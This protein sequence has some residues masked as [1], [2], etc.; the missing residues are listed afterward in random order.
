MWF[1][2]YFFPWEELGGSGRGRDSV[3]RLTNV[4]MHARPRRSA[5]NKAL[6]SASAIIALALAGAATPVRAQQ[7]GDRVRVSLPDST[8][9]GEVAAV[10]D[11]GFD[12]VRDST[13]F[14]FEYQS[15]D[16]LDRSVGTK[17]MGFEGVLLGA[18]I[19]IR[20]G[21]ELIT[22]CAGAIE[23]GSG[24]GAIFLGVIC[25]I[26]GLTIAVVGAPIGAVV[27]GVAGIFIHREEWAAIS[28]DGRHGRLSLLLPRFSP[29]GRVAM[30]LGLRIRIP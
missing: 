13:L 22:G 14:S 7:M 25:F 24:A 30:E 10:T 29:D 17:R 23:D 6:C 27:G 5:V 1:P 15:I 9:I 26:P 12:I 16:G 18:Y 19:P 8:A 20:L 21:F 2:T 11:E 28:L 3:R 4:G